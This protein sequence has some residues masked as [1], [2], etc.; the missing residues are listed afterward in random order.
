MYLG[1]ERVSQMGAT[2]DP[3]SAPLTFLRPSGRLRENSYCDPAQSLPLGDISIA[4]L[5]CR[6]PQ[7]TDSPPARMVR[8]EFN[9][10]P[11]GQENQLM[12]GPERTW[13]GLTP[14]VRGGQGP[15]QYQQ[16]RPY[17]P[18][19]PAR[20]PTAREETTGEGAGRTGIVSLWHRPH[21]AGAKGEAVKEAFLQ[22]VTCDLR[23]KDALELGC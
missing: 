20:T 12:P 5:Q 2:P 4:G 19:G 3:P 10:V 6:C 23:H 15:G 18:L 7:Q 21:S 16:P 9:M 17:P 11:Q 1:T 13:L 14:P 8:R 22:T